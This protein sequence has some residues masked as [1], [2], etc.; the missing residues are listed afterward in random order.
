MTFSRYKFLLAVP[1]PRDYQPFYDSIADIDYVDIFVEKYSEVLTAM[2]NIKSF[3]LSK[4]YDYLIIGQDD[5]HIPPLAPYKIMMDVEYYHFP[6][7]CGWCQI[8]ADRSISNV[9]EVPLPIYENNM[10]KR[11][12]DLIDYLYP[13][14]RLFQYVLEDKR[15]LPITF[16]G[17][18]LCAIDRRTVMAWN[19]KAWF[20]HEFANQR[21]FVEYKGSIGAW[22]GVDNWFSYE[23]TK[24]NLPMVVD[25][26]VFI[27][28]DAPDYDNLL[29]G[30]KKPTSEFYPSV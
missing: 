19:P 18:T 25:L 15:F 23:V 1:S 29:V 17:H 10:N 14:K 16:T 28:H 27:R 6:I 20:F 3:F 2:Q 21:S 7:V 4:D 5:Y 24:R 11:I 26:S 12:P 22:E 13:A 8:G 9:G 30:K